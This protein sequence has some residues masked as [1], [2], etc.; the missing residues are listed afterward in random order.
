[1]ATYP[2]LIDTVDEGMEI[3]STYYRRHPNGPEEINAS[4]IDA[5]EAFVLIEDV[6]GGQ[7]DGITSGQFP[8]AYLKKM[9][10]AAELVTVERATEL[11]NWGRFV[12]DTILSGR[13]FD[14]SPVENRPQRRASGPRSGYVY[15]LQ[16][17]TGFYKIGR[18]INP[19][20]RLKT[21][22]VHLPFE[23]EYICLIQTDDMIGLELELHRR[24]AAKRGNGE[25]F[26]LD[27]ADVA[28]VKGLAK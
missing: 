24:F 2:Y 13:Q 5:S 20:N 25:W 28:Y 12:A 21:F 27:D 15:L 26:A 6:T 17:P 3:L 23:V 19:A 11:S 7:L 1:M 14:Q 4:A 9:H 8:V 16:S 18:A 10:R 22:S